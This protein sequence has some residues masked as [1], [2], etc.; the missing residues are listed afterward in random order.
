MGASVL[1]TIKEIARECNVSIATVS[2]ILNKKNH[3]SEETKTRVMET[4]KRLGYIPNDM[5]RG[6]K[7]SI[8][9]I[10]IITEDLTVFNCAEIVDGINQYLDQRGYFFI[11]GNL[12]LYKKYGNQFY[13][14]EDYGDDIAEEFRK[15]QGKRVDGI[16][17][18]G[19]HSRMIHCIPKELNDNVV[20]AYSMSQ[21]KTQPSVI[22]DD[23][24]AGYDATNYLLGKNLFEIGVIAG[25]KQSYH[26]NERL[27]GYQRAL[28]EHGVLYNPEHVYFGDWTRQT[29]YLGAARLIKEGVRSIFCM[30]DNMASGVYDYINETTLTI[31]KDLSL[32]GFD[33]RELCTVFRP[34]LSS[35]ALPLG[36]IGEK[37]AKLIIDQLEKREG[38]EEVIKIPCEL[39][40]RGSV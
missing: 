16:I 7:K 32:I 34:G 38:K 40:K 4:A 30:N 36:A 13:K 9:T 24:R 18:V 28:F 2:N 29:G 11:L 19:A 8:R 5:A 27:R 12:R 37:A 26:T 6:L 31:G 14:T 3:A 20:L 10:G 25:E 35:V 21:E 39:V 22:I 33:N 17:Y 15:M 1:I 23:E